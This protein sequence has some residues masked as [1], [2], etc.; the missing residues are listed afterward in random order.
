MSGRRPEGVARESRRRAPLQS[1][2]CDRYRL[3][4]DHVYLITLTITLLVV[5]GFRP[6]SLR[7]PISCGVALA[8][9][10]FALMTALPS[11]LS[12]L[13]QRLVQN[14]PLLAFLLGGLGL[15][16]RHD[17]DRRQKNGLRLLKLLVLAT[18]ESER[19]IQTG[20]CNDDRE[21]P[22]EFLMSRADEVVAKVVPDTP[23]SLKSI[24]IGFHRS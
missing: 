5:S 10:V 22:A 17:A 14:R 12:G 4:A 9:L 15:V 16:V 8:K 1:A 2:L 21:R 23:P 3:V 20:A 18:G 11:T 7:D 13:A 19:R 6:Q 24:A